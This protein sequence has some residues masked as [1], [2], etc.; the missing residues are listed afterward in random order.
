MKIQRVGERNRLS[1][2]L[3]SSGLWVY[4]VQECGKIIFVS[5]CYSAKNRSEIVAKCDVTKQFDN[6]MGSVLSNEV[7][8][9]ENET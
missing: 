3:S 2:F 5:Y 7:T 9:N 4:F 6:L 1:L 8:V